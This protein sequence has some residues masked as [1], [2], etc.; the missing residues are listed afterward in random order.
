[1]TVKR[2]NLKIKVIRIL[3]EKYI[4]QKEA[5]DVYQFTVH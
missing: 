5:N 1:M 3:E 4:F 2:S